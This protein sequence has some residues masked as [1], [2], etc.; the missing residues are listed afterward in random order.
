MVIALAFFK[1]VFARSIPMNQAHGLIIAEVYGAC[2][3]ST[4]TTFRAAGA[5][6]RVMRRRARS[7][8]DQEIHGWLSAELSNPATAVTRVRLQ[9]VIGDD[10]A[11]V[12]LDSLE[13]LENRPLC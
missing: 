9:L 11:E 12:S 13:R 2:G 1:G 7:R 10:R 3:V 4:N 8:E 6:R 5:R